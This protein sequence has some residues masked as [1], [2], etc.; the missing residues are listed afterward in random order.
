MASAGS[1]DKQLRIGALL[2]LSSIS[3]QSRAFGSQGIIVPDTSDSFLEFD[4][5]PSEGETPDFF[6]NQLPNVYATALDALESALKNYE[7]WSKNSPD[8]KIVYSALV[9]TKT[10]LIQVSEHENFHIA[11]AGKELL[12]CQCKRTVLGFTMA[13]P[14]ND[15]GVSLMRPTRIGLCKYA[16]RNPVPAESKLMNEIS[17]VLIQEEDPEKPSKVALEKVRLLNAAIPVARNQH[18]AET[19]IHEAYHATSVL[20]GHEYSKNECGATLIEMTAA[21]F[22]MKAQAKDTPTPSGNGYV[23]VSRRLDDGS[24]FARCPGLDEALKTLKQISLSISKGDSKWK[25][26]RPPVFNSAWL[27]TDPQFK[28]DFFRN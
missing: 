25:W 6:R 22:G 11:A 5:S 17:E 8:Y 9:E 4:D 19:L 7:G 23:G 14:V 27:K 24:L 15:D 10:A 3:F 2:L 12:Y 21:A 26:I 20:V 28:G 13:P 18:V 16:F 1:F